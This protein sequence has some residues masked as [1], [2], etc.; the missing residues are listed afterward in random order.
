MQGSGR[1]GDSERAFRAG[2][3]ATWYLWLY[4][5]PLRQKKQWS[6]CPAQLSKENVTMSR[7]KQTNKQAN[8]SMLLFS[9]W[10]PHYLVEGH[11][12]AKTIYTF[13]VISGKTM[14]ESS[15]LFVPAGFLRRRWIG[16]VVVFHS[17]GSELNP[18]FSKRASY[19][20]H[21]TTRADICFGPPE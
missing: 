11:L 17:Q 21:C 1:V 8:Y 19:Q 6:H 18:G 12:Q 16:E 15:A 20:L 9:R 13:L 14:L 10:D 3:R 2:H 5:P 7:K 4:T